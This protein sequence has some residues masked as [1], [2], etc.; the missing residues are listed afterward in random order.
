MVKRFE[1]G[2][3]NDNPL[4]QTP[5]VEDHWPQFENFERRVFLCFLSM[6][7]SRSSQKVEVDVVGVSESWPSM[8][9][10]RSMSLPSVVAESVLLDKRDDTATASEGETKGKE[11]RQDVPLEE[12]K[13]GDSVVNIS[14]A[15]STTVR[16]EE[17][18]HDKLIEDDFAK[19]VLVSKLSSNSSI[20]HVR[21]YLRGVRTCQKR[22]WSVF[23]F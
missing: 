21:R 2:Q 23:F 11:D 19:D 1:T 4:N 8:K 6:E 14:S 16:E 10:V 5:N 9:R 15:G 17:A 3:T 13:S 12:S 18:K 22:F 7:A 20:Q